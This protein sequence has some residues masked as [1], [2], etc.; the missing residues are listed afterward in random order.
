MNDATGTAREAVLIDDDGGLIHD[1]RLSDDQ[2][3]ALF[4][5]SGVELPKHGRGAI[6]IVG[7]VL[8]RVVIRHY[9][10][11]GLVARFIGDWFAWTGAETTRPLREFRVT[12]QLHRAGLPVPEVVAARYVRSEVGYR[13]D[14]ATLL[15]D[16][17]QTLAERLN[18]RA[19]AERFDWWALGALL[20]RFHAFG[21]WHAD[22]NAHNVLVD[23]S[24]RMLL[25]D[26]DRA[27]I[28][29][30]WS[31]KLHGNLDRLARSLRKLGHGAC[32]DGAPWQRFQDGYAARPAAVQAARR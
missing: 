27:R 7:S 31:P 13:A 23:G 6:R 2:A 28:V 32:V 20:S 4:A 22:L 19:F 17:A 29:A 8:G 14:L 16:D 21:L 5:A 24:G 15:I 3:R 11:G 26:F 12:Q 9:R 25:I 18:D 30:P 1:T 10:R